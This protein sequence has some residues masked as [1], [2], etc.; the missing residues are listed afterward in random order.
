MAGGTK[1]RPSSKT[2]YFKLVDINYCVAL[3]KKAFLHRNTQLVPWSTVTWWGEIRTSVIFL[4][5]AGRKMRVCM[6]GPVT[7]IGEQG[8]GWRLKQKQVF[9]ICRMR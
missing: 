3:M 7:I 4:M 5:G 8:S 1:A 6:P 2:N 9:L